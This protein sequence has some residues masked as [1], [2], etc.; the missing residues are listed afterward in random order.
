MWNAAQKGWSTKCFSTLRQKNSTEKLQPPYLSLTF[1]GNRS[2]WSTEGLPYEI[3][4]HCE[5]KIFR[6]I[7][8]IFPTLLSIN[9]FAT[10]IFLKHS[11]EV[12]PYE[13]FRYCETKKIRRKNVNPPFLSLTSFDTRKWWNTKGFP[14]EVVRHCET[15][16]IRQKMVILPPRLIHKLFRSRKFSKTQ[17]RT[18]PPRKFCHW[19]TKNFRRKLLKLPPPLIQEH[20]RYRKFWETQHRRVSLRKVS[21]LW[22]EKNSTEKRQLPF[23]SLTFFEIRSWW[24]T[25]GFPYKFFRHCETKKFRRKN[26]IFP[27]LL[28]MNF[29]A[30]GSFLKHSKEVF[31]YEL[32]R[33]YETKKY[34]TEKR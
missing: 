25:K 16:K 21:V 30:T 14:Y 2:W 22:D 31:P 13:L 4:R 11:K 5:T 17:H 18:G 1:F 15:N 23:L 29:F 12:F 28:S 24:S 7:L 6:K 19:E 34:P 10:G 20:F 27:T 26:L 3:F 32:F 33:H 8:L 9:F